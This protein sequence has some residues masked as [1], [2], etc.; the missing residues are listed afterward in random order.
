MNNP[1]KINSTLLRYILI[2]GGTLSVALGIIG[3]ALPVL[4][5]TPFLLL[6]AFLF[7][8]SSKTLHHWLMNH[9]IWGN[10]LRNYTL[11]KGI[12]MGIKVWAITVLWATILMSAFF[13]IDN[14]W[15]SMLLV[16]VAAGVSLHILTI[17]ILKKDK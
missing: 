11:G 3:I 12:P 13:A 6:A 9:R 1:R 8:R 5:T 16:A 14:T 15:V 10:Y 17:R 4:P 2:A 7:A